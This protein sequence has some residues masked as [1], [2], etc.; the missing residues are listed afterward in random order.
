VG[1]CTGEPGVCSGVAVGK[2]SSGFFGVSEGIRGVYQG[3]CA[4]GGGCGGVGGV[5][6]GR[7]SHFP[8]S[9]YRCPP[10]G[11][12]SI[13]SRTSVTL[14]RRENARVMGRVRD[15]GGVVRPG[16]RLGGEAVRAGPSGSGP[17]V[18][19]VVARSGSALAV[20]VV[21]AVS[22]VHMV[23]C[24]SLL[25]WMWEYGSR[26]RMAMVM[27]GECERVRAMGCMTGRILNVWMI[28][29]SG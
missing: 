12:Q 28:I 13:L 6:V 14:I 16:S 21:A 18:G 2:A 15:K 4:C 17:F 25:S 29:L 22:D 19:R 5:V 8:F 11:V 27:L 24:H 20:C 7:L 3:W 9:S 1:C 23:C 10:V 26:R